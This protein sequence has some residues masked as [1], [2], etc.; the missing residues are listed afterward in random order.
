M[1]PSSSSDG[2][3][4]FE[5]RR[6]ASSAASLIKLARS[7][8]VKPGVAAASTSRSI[9]LSSGLPF[10]C[11][12]R[13]C[14]RPLRSGR[15]TT[16]CRSKR[17]GRAR[18]G[19]GAGPQQRRVEDVGPVRGRDQDDVV[20]QFEPV[21]LDEELVQGLLALV[22]PAAEPGAAVAADSIDLV[23]EDDARGGLLGLLEK[24]ADAR[25]ANADEHLDKV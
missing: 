14:W 16:I 5:P 3:I 19:A 13:I 24:V 8:P 25:G 7:A 10:A 6:A 2:P 17:P 20:L 11:T 4:V 15:S 9:A 22:V 1:I 18:R 12:S 21:H 23:H